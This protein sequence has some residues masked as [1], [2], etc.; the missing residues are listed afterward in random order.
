MVFSLI[1]ISSSPR[2]AILYYIDPVSVD[3]GNDKKNIMRTDFSK[4]G[5]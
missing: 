1:C 2:Y 4:L 5:S 3:S